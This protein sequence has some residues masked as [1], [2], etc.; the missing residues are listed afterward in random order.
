MLLE[1]PQRF[2]TYGAVRIHE[3]IRVIELDSLG[4]RGHRGVYSVSYDVIEEY[5]SQTSIVVPVKD[6][7]FL[8]LE[9]VIAA[10]PHVSRV[11]IVSASSRKPVDRYAYEVDLARSI[12]SATRREIVIV[13]QHDPAWG[14]AL[15][16]TPLEEMID[17]D[18]GTVR[19]GKGEGMLLGVLIAAALGSRYVGFIDSDNYVPGS[20]HEYAWIYYAGFSLSQSPYA[21]VRIKWP[22]KGKLAAGDVYLRRRGRVSMITNS[23]LNYALTLHR[24]V[25]TDIIQTANSGEHALT[26][27]LALRMK[28]ASGFAVEP[29]QLISLLEDCYLG[30][31]EGSCQTLPEGAMIYQVEAR[32]PHIHAER[33]DEHIARM[34][35]ASLG[36]IYHSRLATDKVRERIMRVLRDYGWES[37]PPR[38]RVYD[39]RGV[40]P[41]RVFA[42][43]TAASN[44]VHIFE[45]R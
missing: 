42:T 30:L 4:Y 15:A 36:T 9:G 7:D 13:H 24:R 37:E 27:D 32:N 35:A 34:I 6:E 8:T 14:D 39:P 38:P 5:G 10:I 3:L 43:L 25:E 18:T 2:E 19:K 11:I 44:D 21:M 41:G 16:G 1:Y 40:E 20:A 23:I 28:W 26:L 31:E 45:A 22:F 17:P 12:H 29:Y 33:G